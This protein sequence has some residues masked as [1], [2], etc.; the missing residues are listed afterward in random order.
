MRREEKRR[1]RGRKNMQFLLGLGSPYI[2]FFSI[3]FSFSFPLIHGPWI[4]DRDHKDDDRDIFLL[5]FLN[6][7]TLHTI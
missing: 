6:P 5:F 2:F 3:S 7:C 4:R 1:G